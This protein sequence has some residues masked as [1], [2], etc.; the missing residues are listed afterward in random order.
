[1]PR[2][3]GL[4]NTKIVFESETIKPLY[5]TVIVGMFHFYGQY[6]VTLKCWPHYVSCAAGSKSAAE[7]AI[8]ERVR[9]NGGN[10]ED[11]HCVA[12]IRD[13]VSVTAA[14]GGPL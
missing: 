10:R 3:S 13:L 12:V 11:Y 14:D 5:F 6:S 9:A 7:I 4:E 1:M 8:A 2:N